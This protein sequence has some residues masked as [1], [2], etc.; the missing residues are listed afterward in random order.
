MRIALIATDREFPIFSRCISRME[1]V[2]WVGSHIHATSPLYSEWK[3]Q[4]GPPLFA[5][6]D[7]LIESA[8]AVLVS[9][10]LERRFEHVSHALRKGKAVWSSWPLSVS[11]QD[12]NKLAALADEA[13][14]V[15]QVAHLA[16]R[17]P[18]FKAAFPDL[19]GSR[20]VRVRLSKRF[21]AG[22]ESFAWKSEFQ[23][24]FDRVVA[25]FGYS[26]R[27]IQVRSVPFSRMAH[28]QMRISLEFHS[29]TDA[30]FWWDGL[31]DRNQVRMQFVGADSVSD[32]DLVSP[33]WTFRTWDGEHSA[34][35]V[36]R[37]AIGPVRPLSEDLDAFLR[38]VCLGRGGNLTFAESC[39]VQELYRQ[40]VKQVET[41]A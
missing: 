32:L 18:V 24:C 10:L 40:I 33:S 7:Q 13:R 12:G 1:G 15:N 27:K 25:L 22:D 28:A 3:G 37:R 9:G 31:S 30:E 35:R 11:F 5:S 38:A 16:R 14:V 2:E 34:L 8:E 6:A 20:M 36:E 21:R 41:D 23:P 39:K 17:N 29:G 26:V 19:L 4:L